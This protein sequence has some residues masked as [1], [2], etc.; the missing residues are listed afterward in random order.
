VRVAFCPGA[1]LLVPQLA[2]GAAGE[3]D[4]VRAACDMALATVLTGV[5][6][7]VVVGL[8]RQLTTYAGDCAGTFQPFGLDVRSGGPG[9]VALP[10]SLAVGAWLLD[11]SGHP[12]NRAARTYVELAPDA[13]PDDVDVREALDALGPLESLLVVADG[14]AGRDPKAPGA[15]IDGAAAFDAG[16]AAALAAGDLDHLS[17][18]DRAEAERV[19]CRTK[20]VWSVAANLARRG[21]IS[22]P[23]DPTWPGEVHLLA[24]EAPYGVGYLVAVWT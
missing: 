11:R 10:P 16:L 15:L 21:G 24:D 9:A 12:A 7:V 3:L 1:P 5:G 4:G 18:L 23:E 14:S 20:A 17:S 8:G 13:S 6:R 2:S 22:R 19:W